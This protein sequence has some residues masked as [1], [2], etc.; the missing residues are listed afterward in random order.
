M[1]KPLTWS[2]APF[3]YPFDSVG[4]IYICRIVPS[5]NGFSFDFL[6]IGAEEYTV[7]YRLRS[8]GS[9]TEAGKVKPSGRRDITFEVNGLT[10]NNEYEFYV[11]A[12]IKKSRI[13]L[14][15]CGHFDCEAIINY[16]HPDDEAYAFS[17]R[18]LCSPSIVR[19]PDG[20]LLASMDLFKGGSPQNLTLIYRSDD[21]GKTWH[22]ACEL[23]PCFWGKMFIHKGE[24]YMFGCSTEYGDM[25]IGKSTDGGYSFCEPT[26][27]FRGLNG[28][29]GEV[30]L[31]RNPELVVEYGGRIWNTVEWGS[32][33]KKYH[34]VMAV[35]A[36]V[37]ADLMDSQS[38]EFSEPV[39]YQEWEGLPKGKS[40]GNI[41]G[42]PVVGRDGKLYSM[43]R[44][45]MTGL[46]PGWGLA[47]LYRINTE[48]PAA[49][50]E[51]DRAVKFPAN[52]SKFEVVWDERSGLYWSLATRIVD[53]AHAHSRNLLSLMKSPDL[54]NWTV[55]TDVLDYLDH[56]PKY[57]G[58]QYPDFFIE[59]DDILF[60]C[61]TA[62]NGA[63]GF[64]DSN[65]S[66][67]HRIKNFRQL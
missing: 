17:G 55:A 15:R 20:H 8:S 52:H 24:L 54:D 48:D 13:R 41:E 2:Y 11:E 35:S 62:I 50:M 46:N 65:Y 43:M 28:K 59:G 61:R 40:Y 42:C 39:Q 36:P 7:Y 19:H 38:W 60:Q 37:D 58:F 51:F 14:V 1:K 10:V 33:G 31:H 67:F 22:Y 47:M 29:N 16:L 26:I 45:T 21:D 64:H 56:D 18:Y 5:A 53:E 66:T 34:A 12:G 3:R 32:W 27:L 30:G 44:Y 23:F 9:Y 57:V 49:P 4:D 6:D 63:D 25:L